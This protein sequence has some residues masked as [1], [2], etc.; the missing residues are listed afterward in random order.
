MNASNNYNNDSAI[1]DIYDES[2]LASFSLSL[3][4]LSSDDDL[5]QIIDET[6]VNFDKH[7]SSNVNIIDIYSY[8]LY[9]R[10]TIDERLVNKFS[11]K[12]S[13]DNTS[14]HQHESFN[15]YSES[16]S[17]DIL[18]KIR[19]ARKKS[20]TSQTSQTKKRKR[21]NITRKRREKLCQKAKITSL[22]NRRSRR[23]KVKR[24]CSCCS[25]WLILTQ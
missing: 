20:V 18:I 6:S 14:Q 17:N 12:S 2:N 10:S 4:K 9:S 5:Q 13:I 8:L 21:S 15:E 16:S 1:E 11:A 19:I 25:F 22:L 23:L 24:E 3:T 7:T